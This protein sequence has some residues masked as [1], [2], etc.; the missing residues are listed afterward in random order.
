MKQ[1]DRTLKI[2]REA[3]EIERY[4]YDFYDTLRSQIGD[5]G[6]QVVIA[7]LAGLEVEHMIWLENEYMKQLKS[8]DILDEGHVDSIAI[9]AKEEFFIV[10][11]LPE[12]YR[13][14][15]VAQALDF[16]IEVEERSV[17]F[18]RKAIDMFDDP[19][20]KA[21][22]TKLADFERDHI[23]LLKCNIDSL[24]KNGNWSAPEGL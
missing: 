16:A 10:D 15:D 2:I 20:L 21:L 6:G 14:T 24:K 22:F 18:Y 1:I 3:V 23:K 5:K 9:A 12:M 4:G 7:Y 13:G 11:K 19:N 8:L 17:M